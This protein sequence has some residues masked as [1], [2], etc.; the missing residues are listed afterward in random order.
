MTDLL[1]KGSDWLEDMRETHVTRLAAYVRG[2]DSVEIA[3]TVGRT[4]F[5]I[6]KGG[7][8]ME[9]VEARDYLVT[10]SALIL[11]GAAILPKAGDRILEADGDKAY[12]HEVMA[13]GNEPCWRWSDPYRKTLRIHT[14]QIAVED[15]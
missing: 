12:V 2:T 8:A 5:S 9:R 1:Q 11:D 7:G 10:A 3:V 6:D 4:V 14:K 15:A 13:P